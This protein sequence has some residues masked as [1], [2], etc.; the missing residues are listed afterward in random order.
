[1]VVQLKSH[2]PHENVRLHNCVCPY[3]GDPI[4]VKNRS[5]GDPKRCDE[6]HVV[7]LRFVPKGLLGKQ[8]NL[9]LNAHRKCN[10]KKS[11]L[12]GD[13]SA[14]S[15]QP[16][17]VYGHRESHPQL[18]SEAS[19]K[20][21]TKS[22]RTGKSVRSSNEK[23]ELKRVSP[24]LTMTINFVGPPQIVEERALELAWHHFAAFFFLLTYDQKL[25]RGWW[26]PGECLPI[27]CVSRGDWGNELCLAFMEK[28]NLWNVVFYG[29]TADGHFRL[30]IRKSP[31]KAIWAMAVEWNKKYR[32]L[33][34]AGE[35]TSL[36]EFEEKLPVLKAHIVRQDQVSVLRYR[37][38]TPL[39]DEADILFVWAEA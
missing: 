20:S 38:E 2:P 1:M 27:Q 23:F 28:T 7:G 21:G 8:W 6:E 36:S 17:L 13:I 5:K 39:S 3:C 32:V 12:E 4:D 31:D 26:W 34:V 29:N 9:V 35:T 10:E 25:K 19:R 16:D 18:V 24:E 15:M 30:I 37:Q 11:A 33:A 22:H 14:I